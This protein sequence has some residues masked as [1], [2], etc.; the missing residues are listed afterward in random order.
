MEDL[1]AQALTYTAIGMSVTFAAIGLLVGL[2]YLLTALTREGGEVPAE[3]AVAAVMEGEVAT[4]PPP[5]NDDRY[6]AAAAA[7][8]LA[9]ADL[10]RKRTAEEATA[11]PAGQWRSFVRNQHLTQRVRERGFR[12]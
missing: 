4:A 12:S 6:R 3:E 7:V 11:S 2:M 5:P 8:A 1:L 9:L 10:A